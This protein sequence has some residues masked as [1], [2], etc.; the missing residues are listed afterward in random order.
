MKDGKMA[1]IAQPLL[2]YITGAHIECWITTKTWL[3]KIYGIKDTLLVLFSA[4]KEP[5]SYKAYH[6]P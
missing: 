5:T 6:N 3:L 1:L 4:N 2:D